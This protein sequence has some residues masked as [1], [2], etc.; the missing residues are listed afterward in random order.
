MMQEIS[1]FAKLFAANS[2]SEFLKRLINL[3]NN[4]AMGIMMEIAFFFV[5]TNNI[6]LSAEEVLASLQMDSLHM[7]SHFTLNFTRECASITI[8]QVGIAKFVLVG[9]M[10]IQILLIDKAN[11][12]N[13]AFNA[14]CRQ[15]KVKCLDVRFEL[16]FL[17]AREGAVCTIVTEKFRI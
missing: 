13:V 5:H 11:A 17:I 8:N 16:R 1:S 3:L 7:L 2:A 9:E 15:S 6:T 4:I 12:A 10:L 14:L